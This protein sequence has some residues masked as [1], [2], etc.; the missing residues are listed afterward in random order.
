MKLLNYLTE[1]LIIDWDS[2][3]AAIKNYGEVAFKCDSYYLINREF[4]NE[5]RKLFNRKT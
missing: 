3:I 5:Y 2:L 1:A 4:K